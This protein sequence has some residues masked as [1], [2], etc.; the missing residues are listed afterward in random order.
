MTDQN[1]E[2][3]ML[4]C[5]DAC[6]V[7]HDICLELAMTHCLRLGGKHVEEEHLRLMINCS[8]ICQT[9]ANFMISNSSMH[10]VVCA[11]CAEVCDSCADSCERVGDM[12][13]CVQVCRRCAN[14]CEEM[15]RTPQM[16]T[17]TTAA[18]IHPGHH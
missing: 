7:C 5:I 17:D 13:T 10:A 2:P 15:G 12:E 1:K 18:G 9:A 11:A 6:Q 14:T 4:E 8:E 3:K 16:A